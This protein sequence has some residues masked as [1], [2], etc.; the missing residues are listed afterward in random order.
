MSAGVP[1]GTSSTFQL[2]RSKSLTPAS[3]KVGTLGSAVERTS[4]VTAS[5][6]TAPESIAPL[7]AASPA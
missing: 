2:A 4:P 7:A 5:A 3:L 1:F 6:F